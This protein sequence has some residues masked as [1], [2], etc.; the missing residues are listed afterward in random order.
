MTTRVCLCVS[1]ARPGSPPPRLGVRSGSSWFFVRFVLFALESSAS[2]S[3]QPPLICENPGLPL[4]LGARPGPPPPHPG[5]RSGSSWFFV[6]VVLF[7][8]ESSASHSAQPPLICENPGLPLR[9]GARPGSPPPRPG[10]RS[11]SSWL[12]VRVVL[13]ALESSASHSAQP[14]LICDNPVCLCVSARG[15][16]LRLRVR[17][18]VRLFVVLRALRVI[19]S[20]VK[21]K[22]LSTTAFEL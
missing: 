18:E 2:H 6:R 5:V 9:L 4:R 12:F 14:P 7:A 21:R 3:A 10:V 22:S 15:Q 13:F 8:L 11:G 1:G 20:R 19:R 16:D 17:R